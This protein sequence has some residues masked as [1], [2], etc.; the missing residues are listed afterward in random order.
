MYS[1]LERHKANKYK[2]HHIAVTYKRPDAYTPFIKKC[3]FKCVRMRE[4]TCLEGYFFTGDQ[5]HVAVIVKRAFMGNLQ[6]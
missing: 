5:H 4:Q 6:V 1:A 2:W 3:I